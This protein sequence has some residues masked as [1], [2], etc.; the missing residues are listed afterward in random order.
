M[1]KSK[2][3]LIINSHKS[4]NNKPQNNLHWLN[5]KQIADYCNADLIWSYPT[6]NDDIKKDYDT[7]IFIHAS[8]YSYTDYKWLEESPN[9]NLFYITNEYNLGE[10]RTLWLA[11]KAGRRYRV[12]AN[13]PS[14]ASKVVQK[15]VDSWETVNLNSLCVNENTYPLNRSKDKDLNKIL[16]YGSYREGRYRYFQKYFNFENIVVSSHKK[17]HKKFHD[18]EITPKFVSRIAWDKTG[19]GEYGVSLYI[20]DEKTHTHYNY[21]A[22]RFYEA[23]NYGVVTL[24][25]ASCLT[26][27]EKSGYDIGYEYIVDSVSE[28]EE[29]LRDLPKFKEKWVEQAVLEKESCLK[30]IAEIIS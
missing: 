2:K 1:K 26:T 27:I 30:Q 7:I 17:N 16:Y 25:D 24:F 29:K 12:I 13:H 4:S 22:N 15:Y 11:V 3:I 14:N 21:L 28:L 19:L 5:A 23:L 8:M 20:E 18:L 10:P 9:A 6:V